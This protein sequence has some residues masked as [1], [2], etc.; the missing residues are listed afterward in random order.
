MYKKEIINTEYF[1]FIAITILVGWFLFAFKISIEIVN[2]LLAI[3]ILLIFIFQVLLDTF[4]INI[5]KKL[6]NRVSRN[7]IHLFIISS[8]GLLYS[9]GIFVIISSPEMEK[10]FEYTVA[11]AIISIIFL[12]FMSILFVLTM[13]QLDKFYKVK[14]KIVVK[15]K[16]NNVEEE[17]EEVIIDEDNYILLSKYP[18]GENICYKSVTVKKSEVSKIVQEIETKGIIK[19]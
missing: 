3:D 13:Y 1:R 7:A 10:S 14:R 4:M 18:K 5:K 11:L 2:I 12:V 6:L 19:F 17:F 15:F 9:G 16:E 8:Y